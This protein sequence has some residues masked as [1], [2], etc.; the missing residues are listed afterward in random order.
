[1]KPR[2]F[3]SPQ[4][5]RAWLERNHDTA[6]EL[7][8][9]YY[10]KGAPKSGISYREALD[11]A[12]CFGWIDGKVRTID[13]H[14]YEQRWTPRTAKSPWSAINIAR[15]GELRREGRMAPPGLAAFERR[16]RR[17]QPSDEDLLRAFDRAYRKPFRANA[18][19]W[20]FFSAQPP[21]Y[22]KNATLWV[23]SAKREETRER[24]LAKLMEHSAKA[25]RLPL[26][27]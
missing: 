1:M 20:E 5:F 2:F 25:E 24:R 8:I 18:A 23:M 19:A 15:V 16:D 13:E 26:L 7:W 21:G 6:T 11:E 9:G 10:K 17:P 12:L 22:R 3:R 27:A 4:E 14:T